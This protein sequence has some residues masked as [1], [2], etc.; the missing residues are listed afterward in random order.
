MDTSQDRR[1]GI[2]S[3]ETNFWDRNRNFRENQ[4]ARAPSSS[5]LRFLITL[6]TVFSGMIGTLVCSGEYVLCLISYIFHVSISFGQC[7]VFGS[8]IAWCVALRL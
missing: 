6:E 4:L 8:L 3:I 1:N 2:S 5:E 7:V